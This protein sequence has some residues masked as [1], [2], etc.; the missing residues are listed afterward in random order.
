MW[1]SCGHELS[2]LFLEMVLCPDIAVRW[3]SQNVYQ[4]LASVLT[5]LVLQIS[6][7]P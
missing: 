5:Y 3:F 2:Q 7:L 1:L 6:K 4:F